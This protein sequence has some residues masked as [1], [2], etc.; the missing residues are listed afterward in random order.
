MNCYY[1]SKETAVGSCKS[2]CKGLCIECA[3]DVGDG[4]ACRGKCEDRVKVLNTIIGRSERTIEATGGV[5]RNAG[6]YFGLLAAVFI[7]GGV[8]MIIRTDGSLLSWLLSTLGAVTL[9][10]TITNIRTS[11]ALRN[12]NLNSQS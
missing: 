4:L 10:A 3:V 7:G 1:H 5:F 9:Y 12:N 2:C 8:Y 11:K 6:V